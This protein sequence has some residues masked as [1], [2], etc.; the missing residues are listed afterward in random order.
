MRLLT[1]ERARV[2]QQAS[3]QAMARASFPTALYGIVH[4]PAV[5]LDVS[6]CCNT[7]WLIVGV[8]HSEPRELFHMPQ[9]RARQGKLG[10]P[11]DKNLRDLPEDVRTGRFESGVS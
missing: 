6:K 9:G 8:W 1:E 4:A 3:S 10:P 7:S 11:T 2:A 5:I